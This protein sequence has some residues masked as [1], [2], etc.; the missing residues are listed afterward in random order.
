[1]IDPDQ[2]EAYSAADF[3]EAHQ[4]LV[5]CFVSCFPEL[6]DRDDLHALDLGCGP[7]DVTTRL[8][9]VLP[10]ARITGI[11][12][13]D[14]MLALGRARLRAAGFDDRVQLERRLLPDRTLPPASFDVVVSTSVLH[15][16]V[17][18]AALWATVV[19][20]ARPDAAVFVADLRRPPDTR[21]LD[22]L[23]GATAGEPDVLVTDFRNSLRASYRPDE[24]RAQVAAAGLDLRVEELGERHLVAWG[25]APG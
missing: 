4:R 11:D 22:A 6:A 9:R 17:D 5:D 16:L 19:H 1:M 25:H 8:A 3:A 20:A 12:G 13:S 21:T 15:H 18:P 7:A 2:A 23:V 24:V 10:A 14:A